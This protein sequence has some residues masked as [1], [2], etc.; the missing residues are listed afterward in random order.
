M[1]PLE[2]YRSGDLN[3]DGVVDLLDADEFAL[4]YNAE[5]GNSALT[6]HITVPEPL[7]LLHLLIGS[8]FLV[9]ARF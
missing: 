2:A 4:V 3:S 8:A 1:S 9:V 5:F 7:T 6:L